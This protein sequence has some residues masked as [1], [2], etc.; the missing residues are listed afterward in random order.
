MVNLV[1]IGGGPAG[2]TAARVAAKRKATVSLIEKD[3]LGGLCLN[4]GCIPSKT[5]LSAG[6]KIAEMRR[7]SVLKPLLNETGSV[8]DVWSEM[9]KEKNRVVQK[10]RLSLEKLVKAGGIQILSAQASFLDGH[11][12]RVSNRDKKEEISF[13]KAIVAVG[14][15]PVFP[16]PLDALQAKLLDSDKIL[17][18]E[19]VPKSMIILGGGAVGCE[20][21]CLFNALGARITILEKTNDLLPGEDPL[22]VQ[23]LRKSL[24]KRG[25]QVIPSV[26]VQK[27]E[28]KGGSWE[29]TCS[30]NTVLHAEF[31][32]VCAGRKPN[33][34]SLNLEKA[35]VECS[36]RG[37]QVNSRLQ[38]THPDIYAVGDVNGLSL[39]A[40]AGSAQGEI[41]ALNA[42][43]E[44]T[45]YD[46]SLVPRCLYTWPEVAS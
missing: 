36:S 15:V 28:E 6:K 46:G 32:L 39:L 24:E 33:F 23:T 31:V 29:I 11:R 9:I 43:G 34:G 3:S 5:L 26:T 25:V 41:A 7:S 18:L 1:V 12:L 4:R 38:T 42:L 19:K 16:P 30:N 21:A 44:E 40:H 45:E 8:Q 17:E 35:N 20:F 13:E 27:A 2:E 14:S 22:I 37:I 10:I